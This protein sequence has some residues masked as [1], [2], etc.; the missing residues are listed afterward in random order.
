MHANLDLVDFM[1]QHHSL[2]SV[3]MVDVIL[4]RITSIPYIT[5][6]VIQLNLAYTDIPTSLISC[7]V[8][9]VEK[10]VKMLLS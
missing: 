8:T 7:Y 2:P 1:Q 5:K 4:S 9:F 6:I 3:I 10:C